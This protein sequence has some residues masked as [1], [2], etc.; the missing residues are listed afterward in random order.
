MG[1]SGAEGSTRRGF[2]AGAAAVGGA[3]ALGVGAGE[4]RSELRR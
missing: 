4:L 2:V 1:R 3:A